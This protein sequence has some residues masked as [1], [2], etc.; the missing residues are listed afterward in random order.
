MI[1]KNLEI[2]LLVS[3]TEALL[4]RITPMHEKIPLIQSDL[5]KILAGYHG[6]KSLAF[7]L[8]FLSEKEYYI[9]HDLRL[10][11]GKNYF[12]I[13]VLILTTKYFLIL[14]VKNIA[15]E[16]YFDTEFNQL[17]RTKEGKDSAFA[18]P[19]T[20]L[21]RIESQLK[22]WLKPHISIPIF[23][24]VVIS[25]PASLI[26]ISDPH[27]PFTK[28]IIHR[29]SLPFRIEEISNSI[30]TPTL[31]EHKLKNT[32]KVIKKKNTPLNSSILT[33]YNL[34]K[35]DI[36]KGV[37][38][39][40]CGSLQMSRVNANWYCP[41]CYSKSKKAHINTLIDYYYIFGE[42]ITNQEVREFLQ[43]V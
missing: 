18:D 21:K 24:F 31:D 38:C 6:E 27:S 25:N 22:Q 33:K 4:A 11:D 34:K 9:L 10:F 23:G 32:I 37:I 17:I 14:E 28:K 26:R 42:T 20:Q 15:G 8:S 40:N 36:Q 5:Q 16:L 29:E 19:L 43:K 30:S 12:Q 1:I 41:K 39:E 35:E 2:P 7:V 13:D 3:K